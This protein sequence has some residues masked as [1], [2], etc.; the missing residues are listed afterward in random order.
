MAKA[1]IVKM[2]AL[3]LCGFLLGIIFVLTAQHIRRRMPHA[4][5]LVLPGRFAD[6]RVTAYMTKLGREALLVRNGDYPFI[7]ILKDKSGE[8]YEFNV[9]DG[10]DRRLVCG[11]FKDC[12]LCAITVYNNSDNL[13]FAIRSSGKEGIWER[14]MYV[15]YDLVSKKFTGPH[16]TDVD[17]DGQFDA[18]AVYSQDGTLIGNLI[19]RNGQWQEVDWFNVYEKPPAPVKASVKHGGEYVLFDFEYGKGWRERD[20]NLLDKTETDEEIFNEDMPYA[21]LWTSH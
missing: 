2:V 9:Y 5:D 19:Y 12:R 15:S 1:R 6:I 4:E 13:V 21:L 14:A 3:I 8:V 17:F 20:P 7:T 18:K 11:S 16:Y 10:L